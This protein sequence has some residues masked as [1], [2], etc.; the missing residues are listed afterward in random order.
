MKV[1]LVCTTRIEQVREEVHGLYGE[2][3]DSVSIYAV[4][5]S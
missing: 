5:C 4:W 3:D 1:D 2:S